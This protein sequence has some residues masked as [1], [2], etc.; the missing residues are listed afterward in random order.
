MY[1][2]FEG[3]QVELPEDYL[4][5]E[6]NP[7][8]LIPEEVRARPRDDRFADAIEATSV[9]NPRTWW[10]DTG[11]FGSVGLAVRTISEAWGL[12]VV[13]AVNLMEPLH[14]QDD[15]DCRPKLPTTDGGTV[16]LTAIRMRRSPQVTP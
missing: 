15:G 3:N 12:D 2:T 16:R 7:G 6:M 13:E 5:V 1:L 8:W 9:W 10:Y 11:N 14:L 4:I